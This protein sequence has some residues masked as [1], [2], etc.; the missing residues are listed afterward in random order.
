MQTSR[1]CPHRPS[2]RAAS[3]TRIKTISIL[4]RDYLAAMEMTG[5]NQVIAE[6]TSCLPGTRIV[7]AQNP[8]ITVRHSRRIRARDRDH[9]T[10]MPYSNRTAV[11]PYSAAR[12]HRVAN[13]VHAD[14]P[15]VV[16]AHTQDGRDVS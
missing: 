12:F 16:S 2:P 10:A 14:K 13:S 8:N 5:Q 15:V 1:N 3:G 7:C 11:N 6:F 4:K 9:S